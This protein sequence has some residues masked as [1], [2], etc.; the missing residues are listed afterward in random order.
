MAAPFLDD[1][2]R[3]PAGG[4]APAGLR[5][6]QAA[7]GA[8]RVRRAARAEAPRIVREPSFAAAVDAPAIVLSYPLITPGREGVLL[9]GS[10]RLRVVRAVMGV[11]ALALLSYSVSK[12]FVGAWRRAHETVGE[13]CPAGIAAHPERSLESTRRL[14]DDIHALEADENAVLSVEAPPG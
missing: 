7:L 11:V 10:G 13:V 14:L 6:G 3:P 2:G 12:F 5:P 8:G 1:R 4:E 9:R